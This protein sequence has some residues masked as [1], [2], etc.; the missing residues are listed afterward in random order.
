[1]NRVFATIIFGLL[2]SL[3]LIMEYL[4]N[5]DGLIKFARIISILAVFAFIVFQYFWY[6]KDKKIAIKKKNKKALIKNFRRFKSE[7]YYSTPSFQ[8][9]IKIYF[10]DDEILKLI[11]YKELH[12]MELSKQI[13][14]YESGGIERYEF[15]RDNNPIS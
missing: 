8:Y 12:L 3:D 9:Y 5:I 1:M 7:I 4:T 14:S 13:N 11:K 6:R 2:T 10:S 15:N